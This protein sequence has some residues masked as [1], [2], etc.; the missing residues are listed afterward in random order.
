M[1]HLW[2]NWHPRKLM[3]L[4]KTLFWSDK[5]FSSRTCLTTLDFYSVAFLILLTIF[6]KRIL[7]L[8]VCS[9]FTGFLLTKSL[10]C[11]SISFFK[12]C[13]NRGRSFCRLQ[14]FPGQLR[15]H[16]GDYFA[17][18]ALQPDP[19]SL[20][21]YLLQFE[22]QTKNSSEIWRIDTFQGRQFCWFFAL[23]SEK[24]LL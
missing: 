11:T 1:V 16:K 22:K 2:K 6:F 18:V 13:K 17:P 19:W 5:Q 15:V 12:S 23:P 4:T 3:T 9:I 20:K 10:F 14:R 24:G 21:T 7:P 8:H